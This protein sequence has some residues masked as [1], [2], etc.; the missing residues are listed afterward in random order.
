MVERC[1]STSGVMRIQYV[2]GMQVYF[3]SDNAFDDDVLVHRLASFR[4]RQSHVN[5]NL[6]FPFCWLE[7]HALHREARQEVF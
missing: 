3:S 7:E 2:V 6:F 4:R 1:A 5:A